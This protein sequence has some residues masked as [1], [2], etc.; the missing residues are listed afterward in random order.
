MKLLLDADSLVFKAAMT[1]KS[2][3]AARKNVVKRVKEVSEACFADE[4][5]MYVKGRG[6]YRYNVYPQYKGKRKSQDLDQ[7]IKDRLNAGHD[8]LVKLG[9]VFVDGLEAD[10]LVCMAAYACMEADEDFVIGYIDKDLLQIPGNHYNYDKQEFIFMDPDE[11]DMFFW[12]QC[13]EGD[14]IDNI[15][16]VRGIGP[17]KAAVILEG[18]KFGDRH[19]V[20]QA[21]YTEVYGALGGTNFDQYAASLWLLREQ[22]QIFDDWLKEL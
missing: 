15:P 9:A 21:K 17:A 13:L 3:A 6:N 7:E 2:E 10:D 5:I 8:E 16:G 12:T 19:N 4:T 18:S 11:A 20:V 14:S 1:T 22:G